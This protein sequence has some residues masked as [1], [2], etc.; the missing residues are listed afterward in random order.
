MLFSIGNTPPGKK[1]S[2]DVYPIERAQHAAP[3]D[4]PQTTSFTQVTTKNGKG[5]TVVFDAA[6]L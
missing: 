6:G 3:D 2:V 1:A 5:L 4:T